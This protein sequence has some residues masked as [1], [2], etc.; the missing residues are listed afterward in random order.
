[1]SVSLA[2]SNFHSPVNSLLLHPR[3]SVS[4]SKFGDLQVMQ[5]CALEIVFCGFPALE[6]GR[7]AAWYAALVE[8]ALIG[9]RSCVRAPV[10]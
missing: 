9:L 5:A 2:L 8:A 4:Y 6:F 3:S 7:F 1:M 10:P